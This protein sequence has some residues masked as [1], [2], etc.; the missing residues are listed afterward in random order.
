M[1]QDE[2]FQKAIEL[3]HKAADNPDMDPQFVFRPGWREAAIL[4]KQFLRLVRKDIIGEL[5]QAAK[6][7]VAATPVVIVHSDGFKGKH[8]P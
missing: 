8:S 4:G 6:K 3:A 5:A 7:R 2:E 1:T